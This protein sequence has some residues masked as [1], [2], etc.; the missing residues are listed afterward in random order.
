MYV[1]DALATD[2]FT[3]RNIS[4]TNPTRKFVNRM[5][6][7][8]RQLSWLDDGP[9]IAR[10]AHKTSGLC[11]GE[12]LYRGSGQ[13]FRGSPDGPVLNDLPDRT[14]ENVLEWAWCVTIHNTIGETFTDPYTIWD[15]GHPLFSKAL[16]YTAVTRGISLAQI[17]FRS[18]VPKN[19]VAI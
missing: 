13:W 10:K 4:F 8:M 3:N 5:F 19:A 16:M 7:R 15:T 11:K 14:S 12:M 6:V 17:T 9:Y 18:C 2:H 1:L